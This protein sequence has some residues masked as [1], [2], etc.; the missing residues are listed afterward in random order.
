MWTTYLLHFSN[1]TVVSRLYYVRCVPKRIPDI[2]DCN[3]KEDCQSLIL[4]VRIVLTQLAIVQLLKFPIHRIC[5]SALTG[6]N[7]THEIAV[8]MDKK[9]QKTSHTLLIVT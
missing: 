9:R 4:L 8:E 1:I 5:A 6:E 3:L 2:I 7:G